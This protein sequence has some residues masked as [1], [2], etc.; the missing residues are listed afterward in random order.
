MN[1]PRGNELNNLRH[2][3]FTLKEDDIPQSLN[4]PSS[5]I[6]LSE[7]TLKSYNFEK[8][9]NI[10]T[11]YDELKRQ[12]TEKR[13]RVESITLDSLSLT[14]N[15]SNQQQQQQL[16]QQS[17][18]QAPVD[19]SQSPT[20]AQVESNTLPLSSRSNGNGSDPNIATAI[21]TAVSTV[22]VNTSTAQIAVAQIAN[23]PI[24]PPKPSKEQL[25]ESAILSMMQ[26]TK[27][28]RNVCT[29]YLDSM[30]WDLNAALTMYFE[31]IEQ[32]NS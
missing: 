24:P 13:E 29:F 7:M 20:P 26:Q 25:Q 14:S 30:N 6:T 18:V 17:P 10:I 9:L 19:S 28:E 23:P 31:M 15:N 27:Q 8:E 2:A 21:V 12:D 11:N 16:Q 1:S 3:I 4:I 32:T 5:F 22:D